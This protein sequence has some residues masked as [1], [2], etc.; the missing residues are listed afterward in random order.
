MKPTMK[1]LELGKIPDLGE[2]AREVREKWISKER[3]NRVKKQLNLCCKELE[4]LKKVASNTYQ[5]S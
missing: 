2:V 4:K 5:R 3:E 1:W